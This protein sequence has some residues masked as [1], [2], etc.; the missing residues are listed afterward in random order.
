VH[1]AIGQGAAL[2]TE[3]KPSGQTQAP[4]PGVPEKPGKSRRCIDRATVV[5]YE[6]AARSVSVRAVSKRDKKRLKSHGVICRAENHF[7]KH[8]HFPDM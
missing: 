8:L 4:S 1:Q 6:H 2:G 5:E 7:E 3:G